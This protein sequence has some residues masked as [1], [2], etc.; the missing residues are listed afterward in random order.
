MITIFDKW[1]E[2]G[3]ILS[4]FCHLDS[5]FQVWYDIVKES[6]KGTKTV[7]HVEA[8]F[9]FAFSEDIMGK[10]EIVYIPI[11][12]LK[13]YKNN[14]R[15]IPETAVNAVCQA[16]TDVGFRRP[17]DIRPDFTLINGHTRLK[18]AKKLGYKELPCIICSDLDEK[19]I[20]KWRIEDNKTGE[21]S[22]WDADKLEEELEDID[23]GDPEF[24]DFDFEDDLQKKKRWEKS[25]ALCDLK[26]K[27]ALHKAGNLYY[28]SMMKAGKTG[29]PLAEIKQPENVT[30]FAAT[31]A[32]FLRCS[33]G[34]N[35][36]EGS[37]CIVTTP[38]RRHGKG[39]HFA[40]AVCNAL[41]LELRIPFYPDAVICHNRNRV[42]PL[43]E[44]EVWPNEKNVILY[45]DILTTGCT[46]A[47]TRALLVEGGYT[48][49]T[50]I[51]IDNH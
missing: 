45:D 26:D 12:K 6:C 18:A 32:E 46:A 36:S 37:W 10:Q 41:S 3:T 23:F 19:Q 17:I 22:S 24:F 1:H 43:F 4:P 7:L 30:L 47:E 40:T 20:K 39:F 16:I 28:Q 25:K 11:S 34:G 2:F 42:H 44:V 9:S 31:A 48:V 49:Q 50:V 14:P 35:F 8:V 27:L 5:R 38:R 33:M 13:P 21:Y 15:K 29:K 51:S